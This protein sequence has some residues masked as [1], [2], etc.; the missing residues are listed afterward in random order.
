MSLP[1]IGGLPS[2]AAL[3]RTDLLAPPVAAALA[4]WE[5]AGRAVVV[6]IDPELAETAALNEAYDLSP[7]DSANCV[8]V[9]GRRAGEERIGACVVR[10]DTRA[11]VN[12]VVRKL[13]DARKVSFHP[14]ERAVEETGMEHG[15]ITP[16][17]LPRDW[18]IFVD[19][20]VADI[21]HALI[22]SG[23]RRSKLLLPGADL[24]RLPGVEVVEGLAR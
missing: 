15:G 4:V 13:L 24:V 23:L 18:R 14:H 1:S 20:T 12:T 5:H 8:V 6:E 19:A 3:D 17:G 16:V 2:Y 11:E 7:A 22:G 10:A 9:S 21:P